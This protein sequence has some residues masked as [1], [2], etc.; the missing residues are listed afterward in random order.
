MM[1]D[2]YA[3]NYQ[4]LSKPSLNSDR[5]SIHV[6]FFIKRGHIPQIDVHIALA[7]TN[8]QVEGETSQ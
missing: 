6:I 4:I 5:Q 2:I 7:Q 1:H 3:L 8:S